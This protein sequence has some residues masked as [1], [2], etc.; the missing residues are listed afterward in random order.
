MRQRVLMVTLL[1]LLLSGCNIF[2]VCG[3]SPPLT[4]SAGIDQTVSVGS[5]VNLDGSQ[6]NPN[7]AYLWS[8]VEK[9][10]SS[11]ALLAQPETLS[12]SF[13]A[14]L[15][16]S[17]VVRLELKTTDGAPLGNDEVVVTAQ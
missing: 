6:S 11:Q 10:A 14:D 5:L 2:P 3:C 8:F 12:P 15:A 1:V 4:V 16:G 9:P 13:T 7:Y 17:Y